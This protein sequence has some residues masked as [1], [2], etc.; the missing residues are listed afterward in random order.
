MA[1][2]LRSRDS[3]KERRLSTRARP[4]QPV[5]GVDLSSGAT[6]RLRDFS[7]RAFAVEAPDPMADGRARLF[8]FPLGLGRIAFKGIPRRRAR[9]RPLNGQPRYLVAL[10]FLKSTPTNTLAVEYFV[11]SLRGEVA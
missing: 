4:R 1:T 7:A 10:E 11:R 8:E 6:V 5:E 3:R 2:P 9:L